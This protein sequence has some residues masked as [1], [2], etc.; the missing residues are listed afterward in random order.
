MLIF[1]HFSVSSENSYTCFDVD[2][3]EDVIDDVCDDT[4]DDDC[5]V[6]NG[7]SFRD[8]NDINPLC[9]N[10]DRD[11]RIR[12][13]SRFKFGCLLDRSFGWFCD[14][15]RTLAGGSVVFGKVMRS[16]SSDFMDDVSVSHSAKSAIIL[17]TILFLL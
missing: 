9:R 2:D 12:F 13:E 6:D 7:E 15:K 10:E 3:D 17:S 8:T 14:N 11:I 4:H 16:V 5:D 1:S